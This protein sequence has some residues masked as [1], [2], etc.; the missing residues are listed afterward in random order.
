MNTL[1]LDLTDWDLVADSNGN[2]AMATAPYSRAQDVASYIRTFEGEC[3][4]NTDIGIPYFSQILGH[5]PP[6]TLFQEYMADAAEEVPGV[7]RAE[8]TVQS[9][10]DRTVSG[11]VLFIDEDSSE[12]AV[13][14]L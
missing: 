12:N 6:I 2:I 8:C 9:L 14:L 4:Y 13:N 3:Y 11:Q 1:L 10:V 7:E 5:T